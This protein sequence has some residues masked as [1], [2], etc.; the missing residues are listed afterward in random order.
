VTARAHVERWLADYV[1]A[2]KSYDRDAIGALYAE[3]AEC[4]YHPYD[5]PIKG[6]EAI[7]ESWFGIGEGAPGQDAPGTYEA[8]YR[9]VAIDGD[10]AVV[11]GVSRYTDPPTVYDNCFVIRFDGE[12]R[13]REFT[14]W[15]IE[16]PPEGA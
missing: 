10:V 14:E 3:E 5:D 8:E 15:F 9:P 13:C 12:G 11:V 16:R 7:V 1:E 4:R 6:R 2:W